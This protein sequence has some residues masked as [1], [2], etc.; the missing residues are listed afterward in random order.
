VI[1]IREKDESKTEK[2]GQSAKDIAEIMVKN[3]KANMVNPNF[4]AE[5]EERL[6]NARDKALKKMKER[7]N[8][9]K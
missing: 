4:W 5:K 1:L 3:M 6:Q 7:Q 8:N 2:K 9:E